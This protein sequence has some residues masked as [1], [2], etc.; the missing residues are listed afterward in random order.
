MPAMLRDGF[1]ASAWKPYRERPRRFVMQALEHW[2]NQVSISFS[3]ISRSV[4]TRN[5]TP[6]P[7]VSAPLDQSPAVAKPCHRHYTHKTWK[8][9][10]LTRSRLVLQS[11]HSMVEYVPSCARGCRVAESVPGDYRPFPAPAT[12]HAFSSALGRLLFQGQRAVRALAAQPSPL[13][14]GHSQLAHP[15][16]AVHPRQTVGH[17]DHA[18]GLSFGSLPV[19]LALVL[20]THRY[21]HAHSLLVVAIARRASAYLS[22]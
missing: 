9:P 21:L 2:N 18:H 10:T 5:L 3:V 22:S 20:A 8:Q 11:F 1:H 19:T 13:G 15:P 14:S 17:P 16:G 4:A 7:R 12:D 6:N